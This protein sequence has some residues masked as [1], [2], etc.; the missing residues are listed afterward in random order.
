MCKRT[1]KQKPKINLRRFESNF[2][3]Q[4]RVQRL[5]Q[6]TNL[7]RPT[8]LVSLSSSEFVNLVHD[9]AQHMHI[10]HNNEN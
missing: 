2:P 7:N 6:V 5:N 10:T 3:E 8:C 1:E 4:T 9:L